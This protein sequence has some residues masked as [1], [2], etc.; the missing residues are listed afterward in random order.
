MENVGRTVSASNQTIWRYQN[1]SDMRDFQPGL[2]SF[3]VAAWFH[4]LPVCFVI[5]FFQQTTHR[6]GWA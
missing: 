1:L 4:L 6:V 2:A 3:A 5:G